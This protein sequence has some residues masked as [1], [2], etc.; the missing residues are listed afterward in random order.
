MVIGVDR[1]MVLVCDFVSA[2]RPIFLSCDVPVSRQIIR[3]HNWKCGR[4]HMLDCLFVCFF[5]EKVKDH[6]RM[7]VLVGTE[8][9]CKQDRYCGHILHR[10]YQHCNHS[11]KLLML[12]AGSSNCSHILLQR[13]YPQ[14]PQRLYPPQQPSTEV[15]FP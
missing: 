3:D 12:V 8:W 13:L 6:L 15:E 10:V 9:G 1:R 11:H 14:I 4:L 2:D 5:V 7:H